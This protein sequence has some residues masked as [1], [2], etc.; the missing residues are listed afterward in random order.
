MN[1]IIAQK[2][3]LHCSLERA[4]AM[5]IDNEQIQTWLTRIADVE[6]EVGGRYELFWDPDDPEQ[7]GTRGCKITAIEPEALLAFEWKGP[8]QF[9][10]MNEV[11]PLTHVAVFFAPCNEVLTPCTD[12][13][14]LHTGWGT[15]KDWDEARRYCARAWEDAFARLEALING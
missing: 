5:F 14:L 15:T 2:A 12:I 8:R 1:K 3:R 6:P 13:Y 7:D 9:D 4:F 11:D 10:F